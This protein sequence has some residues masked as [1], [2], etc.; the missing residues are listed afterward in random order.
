MQDLVRYA[1]SAALC[2]KWN[3]AIV[4]NLSILKDKE[5][6][7]DAMNRLAHAYTQTGK[8][9]EAKHLYKKIL[10]L[11]R[12][13]TIAHKN[14][15]KINKIS[16]GKIT[17]ILKSVLSLSPSLFLEEPG[18]TKTINLIHPAPLNILSILSVGDPVILY[19]KK[20]TIEVRTPDKIYLGALPDDIAFRLIRLIKGGNCYEVCIK[21]ATKNSLS[22]F[23]RETKRGKRFLNQPSFIAS[24]RQPGGKESKTPEPAETEEKSDSHDEWDE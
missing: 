20:H 3:E 2:H 18:R 17:P 4:T 21:C 13:N 15:E 10:S 16:K 11:D 23:M 1:I 24:P 8:V 19:P 12:Y 22:V 9:D 6:D 7:L 5:T 14:L